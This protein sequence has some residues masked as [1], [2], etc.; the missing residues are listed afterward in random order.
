MGAGLTKRRFLTI[1]A[2]SLGVG[3]LPLGSSARRATYHLIEWRGLSLGAVATIRIHH[4]DKHAAERTLRNVVAEARRLEAIF[5]LYR[6]DSALSELNLRGVLLSPPPELCN[7]MDLCDRIWH[8]TGGV[9]DPTVQALWKCYADH[10]SNAAALRGNLELELEKALQFVGWPGVD[11]S[12]D[13]IVLS[14][15]GMALTLNG[16]AQGYIT[17]RVVELLRDGGIDSCLVNMGEIRTLG[18]PDAEAW[19][20]ALRGPTGAE[21]ATVTLDTMN[22]AI[23]S[24]GAAG[25]QFDTDGRSNHLFNPATGR[26]ADPAR[27]ITVVTSRAAEADALSTA[28]SLMD[29]PAIAAVLAHIGSARVYA[30]MIEGT[31]EIGGGSG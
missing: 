19:R 5:S 12:R 4:S 18:S 20:I 25:Y 23:A 10:F 14:R 27:T 11:F 31:R 9:F 21:S 15:R 22:E 26:C 6:A 16:I 30:T 7:L 2:A 3:A 8:V 28:F 29:D 13:R 24:S 17:D 1:S